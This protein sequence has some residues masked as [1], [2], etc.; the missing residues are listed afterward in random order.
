MLSDFLAFLVVTGL[1]PCQVNVDVILAFLKYL[2]DNSLSVTNICNY[3]AGLRT[4]FIIHRLPT[5]PYTDEKI[6]MFV[7]SARKNRPLMVKSNSIFT[8]QML[9]DIVA[10]T[11]TLEF[12]IFFL[13]VYLLAMF[14]FLR[15][16]NMVPHAK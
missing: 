3:L 9:L 2:A 5:H 13:S 16:S 12:S 11:E 10:A 6:Q 8:E 14:S 4:M 15:L 1:T 7:K